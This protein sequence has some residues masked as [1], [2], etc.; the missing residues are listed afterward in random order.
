MLDPALNKRFLYLAS[1]LV[2]QYA[3]QNWA[4]FVIQMIMSSECEDLASAYGVTSSFTN[5]AGS[6]STALYT[7]VSVRVG[8]NLGEGW[9]AAAK[10]VMNMGFMLAA[11][12]GGLISIVLY[13]FRGQLARLFCDPTTDEGASCVPVNALSVSVAGHV[14]LYYFLN[15]MM[16]A[17]WAPLEG[18]MRTML[19]SAALTI[20]MWGVTVPFSW[21]TIK[22]GWF[23]VTVDP[24]GTAVCDAAQCAADGVSLAEAQLAASW[25]VGNMGMLTTMGLMLWACLTS[26]W[27]DLARQAQESAEIIEEGGDGDG[28]GRDGSE[29]SS[30]AGG[31]AAAEPEGPSGF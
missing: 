16:W 21:L 6:V 20:G 5:T 3:M 18:Q 11:G 15:S 19:P 28:G 17:F 4:W 7:A 9:P 29:S 24:T 2:V 31:A 10:S 14:S 26:D 12:A 22:S 8:T 13:L 23:G 27:D 1:P 25:W 30:D